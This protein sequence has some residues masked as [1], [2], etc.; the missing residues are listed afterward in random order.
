[1]KKL[2]INKRLNEAEIVVT[3]PKDFASIKQQT[4]DKDTII[5]TDD[6]DDIN[7]DEINLDESDEFL[8]SQNTD[9]VYDGFELK[10]NVKMFFEKLQTN[11]TL[12]DYLKKI[13]TDTEKYQFFN[14]M[15]EFVGLPIERLAY[16]V[17]DFKKQNKVTESTNPKIKKGRLIKL[18]NK[19]LKIK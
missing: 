19:K 7:L 10:P 13:D 3:D 2:V 8:A 15:A 5:V 1:M 12:M 14:N 4:D 11:S 6:N 9:N 16:L 17:S 18:V